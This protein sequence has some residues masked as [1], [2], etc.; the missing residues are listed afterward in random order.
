MTFTEPRNTDYFKPR[1]MKDGLTLSEL[2]RFVGC[3]PSWIRR[4]ESQDR[5]PKAARVKRG[6][7]DVRIWTKAQA[8]E[9]KRIIAAHHPGR[10]RGS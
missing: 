5:I 8:D 1:N 10:P 2:A 6:K 3:D 4:L 9:I 7:L